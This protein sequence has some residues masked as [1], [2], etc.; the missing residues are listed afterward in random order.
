MCRRCHDDWG[1]GITKPMNS[2]IDSLWGE[3]T[4]DQL[5]VFATRNSFSKGTNLDSVDYRLKLEKF[6]KEKTKHL[7]SGNMT[8]KESME[9]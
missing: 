7:Q 5:E 3:G 9:N 6:Y 1:K 2:A 4:S 8:A